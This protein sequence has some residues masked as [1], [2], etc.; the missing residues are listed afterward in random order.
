[1]RSRVLI[2]AACFFAGAIFCRADDSR[3]VEL[4]AVASTDST[5]I[6]PDSVFEVTVSLMNPTNVVQH[7]RIPDCGWD[8]VW[9][10]NNRHV[11]WDF[12]DCDY[13][14]VISVD[15]DP[16]DSYVF[17]KPL[18]MY[19]TGGTKESHIEFKMGFKEST[20]GKTLWSDPVGIDVIP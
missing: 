5:E 16:G 10:S 15:I 12:W 18:R 7:V 6:H 14:D 1:M 20:F 11:T 2:L 17:P 9:R 19:V 8:R 4:K 13:N 3:H